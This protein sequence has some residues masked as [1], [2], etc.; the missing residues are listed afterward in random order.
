MFLDPSV[1][2]FKVQNEMNAYLE[3]QSTFAHT[4]HVLFGAFEFH[5]NYMRLPG[6]KVGIFIAITSS[7]TKY[8]TFLF[9][10]GIQYFILETIRLYQELD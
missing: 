10:H 7:K 6:S 4:L 2:S 5:I 3:D 9:N 8:L 1:E